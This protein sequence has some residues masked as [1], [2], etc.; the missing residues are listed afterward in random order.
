MRF[1]KNSLLKQW[2]SSGNS[3][4]KLTH[5][6]GATESDNQCFA[7]YLNAEGFCYYIFFPKCKDLLE[8]S[9]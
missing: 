9:R 3:N 8:T 6:Y 7:S 1:K 5:I 2:V 4:D